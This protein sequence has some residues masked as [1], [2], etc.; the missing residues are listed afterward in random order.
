MR[1][2]KSMNEPVNFS[3]PHEDCV[4]RSSV[5]LNFGS[6]CFSTSAALGFLMPAAYRSWLETSPR[7]VKEAVP[8]QRQVMHRSMEITP[9]LASPSQGR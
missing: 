9:P 7:D 5:L 2:G 1:S 8:S 3:L 6:P 4:D